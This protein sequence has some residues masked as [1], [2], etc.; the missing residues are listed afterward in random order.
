MSKQVRMRLNINRAL[1]ESA[2]K[3]GTRRGLLAAMEE[4][5]RVSKQ[6]VPL[7]TGILKASGKASVSNDGKTGCYS[8]DTKYAV[9]QHE[10][11]T[12]NHQRGRKAKYLEDPLNDKQ[13]QENMLTLVQGSYTELK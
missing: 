6:Q 9:R 2:I 13:V 8:Y 11:L 10:V 4:L 7:D 1:A 5:G 12:Y 3:T